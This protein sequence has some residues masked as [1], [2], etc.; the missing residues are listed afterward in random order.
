MNKESFQSMCYGRRRVDSSPMV[1][2]EVVTS[3]WILADRVKY[4]R[5]YLVMAP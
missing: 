4:M 2:R 1:A 5:V 3:I